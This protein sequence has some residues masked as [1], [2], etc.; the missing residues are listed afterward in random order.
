MKEMLVMY[1]HY[2]K[3][4][5]KSVADLLSTLD[6]HTRNEGGKCYYGSIH[7]GFRHIYGSILYFQGVIRASMPSSA[8]YMGEIAL[9]FPEEG[10][11][12]E[13]AF[14]SLCACLEKADQGTIDFVASLS[15]NDLRVP[16]KLDWYSD[17]ST[18]PLYFFLN[19]IFVHGTHHRGQISQILDELKIEHDFSSIDLEFLGE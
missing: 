3:R 9:S 8:A 1:A 5:D 6:I 12:D 2:S 15:D 19:Q 18:V 7:G 17:R 10:D 16:V 14:A 4:A 11:L 13:G